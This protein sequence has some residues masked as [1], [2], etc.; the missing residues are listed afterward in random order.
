M[1]PIR[2]NREK[3]LAE[4]LQLW[5]KTMRFAEPRIQEQRVIGLWHETMG[6][7]I[8]RYTQSVK[9]V[10]GILYIQIESAPLR[11]ELFHNR[12]KIRTRLNTELGTE[13][14]TQ[15]VIR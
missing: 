8:S 13:Y 3:T 4:V 9:V 10:K 12:E 6:N 14:I 1:Q 2:Q 7:L 5:V 15:V 11:Q